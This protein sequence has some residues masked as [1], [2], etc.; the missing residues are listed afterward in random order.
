[1]GIQDDL[2]SLKTLKPYHPNFDF[3]CNKLQLDLEYGLGNGEIT[4]AQYK[5]FSEEIKK[6]KILPPSLVYVDMAP[7]MKKN[8]EF[9]CNVEKLGNLRNYLDSRY[10][11]LKTLAKDNGTFLKAVTDEL[12]E[13]VKAKDKE[14]TFDLFYF[15]NCYVRCHDIAELTEMSWFWDSNTGK[16]K[17][18]Y[19]VIQTITDFEYKIMY[20]LYR[21]LEMCKKNGTKLNISV[22]TETTGLNIYNLSE[23]NE[24]RDHC[25]A[26]PI[27]W[28]PD[29]AYVIFTDMEYFSNVPNQ[30]AIDRLAQL[31]E[32]F[33]GERTIT[34]YEPPQDYWNENKVVT[35]QDVINASTGMCDLAQDC[36][37]AKESPKDS[38][39]VKESTEDSNTVKGSQT[40]ST[41]VKQMSFFGNTEV[42]NQEDSHQDSTNDFID[43]AGS[44][45]LADF[46]DNFEL[47]D[48]LNPFGEQSAKTTDDLTT[49]DTL[50][51]L[52]CH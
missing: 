26:I 6:T 35:L 41:Q 1:M 31:F 51:L 43:Y 44:T 3:H 45:E 9:F 23:N 22:D 49:T 14:K 52:K 8:F 15:Y 47:T 11:T 13:S 17:K 27:S 42:V 7:I 48:N 10:G 50:T 19:E 46:T 18:H 25:V 2:Q 34:I 33:K 36:N 39:T 4:L 30:Y 12:L 32:N 20:Q 37:T 38:N 5:Q 24:D 21:E 29:T 40:T 16:M 28:K